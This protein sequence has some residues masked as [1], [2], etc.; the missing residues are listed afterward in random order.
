MLD[1]LGWANYRLGEYDR[2]QPACSRLVASM[3]GMPLFHCHLE[4]DSHKAG[5]DVLAKRHLQ[6][7]FCKSA[8]SQL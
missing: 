3:P 7:G 6:R 8:G 5:D 4:M 2:L 1:T